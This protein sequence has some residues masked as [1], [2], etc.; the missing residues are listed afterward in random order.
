MPEENKKA[1]ENWLER[2][3]SHQTREMAAARG[4][5][6]HSSAE[7][8]LKNW[9]NDWHVQQLN[10]TQQLEAWRRWLTSRT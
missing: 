2:P 4:T 7:Y 10:Q 1:L 8:V 9:L 6:A 5:A 3:G